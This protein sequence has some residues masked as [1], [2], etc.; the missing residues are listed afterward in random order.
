VKRVEEAERIFLGTEGF[1]NKLVALEV[2]LED[3]T[4]VPPPFID[5]P[6]LR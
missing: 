3:E 6:A 4:K 2:A 5:G 1:E